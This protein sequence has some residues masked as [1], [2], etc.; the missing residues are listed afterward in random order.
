MLK[1]HEVIDEEDDLRLEQIPER[2]PALGLLLGR[3][4]P[5]VAVL[6]RERH[7]VDQRRALLLLL[8]LLLLS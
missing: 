6:G 7:R 3:G 4:H 2:L 5:A 8:L 1:D